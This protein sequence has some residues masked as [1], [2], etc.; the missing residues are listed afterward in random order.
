MLRFLIK[1]PIAVL[2]SFLGFLILGIVVFNILPI[3]L[4]PNVAIPQINVQL[5]YP[6]TAVREI[7]NTITQPLRNQLLQ[8]GQIKNIESLSRSGSATIRLQFDYS[9]NI[10]LAFIEVNEKIDQ[11]INYLPKDLERPR[12]IKANVSDIP[13]FY[14]SI[15]PKENN[16]SSLLELSEFT[17]SVLKRRIEQLPEVA[18]VD[19]SGFAKPQLI[20]QPDPIVFQSL[21][22][23]E[24][25]ISNALK[26]NNINLGNIL[27]KD[28][29]YQYNIRFLSEL[30]TK[31]DVENIFL[32]ISNRTLQLKDVAK[33]QLIE[34]PRRSLFLHNG[35]EGIIFS[36]RKQADAQLFAL[37]ASFEELLTAFK[38]DYPQ[39][40]FYV[41]N[42]QSELLEVSIDNLRTSLLYG[43]CFA[44]LVM[45]LFF[46]E[47]QMPLLI[48]IA[49]PVTLIISGFIFYLLG[50][51]INIISLSGL[52][53]GV[54]LMIDNSIIVIEN[55]RQ[56]QST[57]P[58]ITDACAEGANEV[59][60][61]LISS[62]LT[63][64]S[65]FLPLIFLSG[66]AGALFYDQAMSIMITLGTSLIVAY[67]LLPTLIR[68]SSN[69]RIIE[70]DIFRKNLFTR[71][72]DF[73]LRFKWVFI[74]LFLAFPT[75]TFFSLLSVG[76]AGSQIA[77]ESFPKLTRNALAINIDWNDAITVEESAKRINEFT[78]QYASN[79]SVST[80][81]IGE[82]QFLIQEEEK[83]INELS[84]LLFA[85]EESQLIPLKEELRD[86]FSNK[87]P[88]VIVNVE[89]QKNIFDQVFANTQAPLILDI[90]SSQS[91][92]TPSL[93]SI[94]D[95]SIWLKQQGI[96]YTFPATEE[97][98]FIQIL[99]EKAL[100][101][102]V[103]YQT[104]N[105]K[106]QSLFS[107]NFIGT[108]KSSEQYIPIN[109]GSKPKSLFRQLN[110][111]LITNNQKQY[112]PL[113]EFIQIE[114]STDYKTITA[115]KGGEALRL[116]LD[117]FSESLIKKIKEK[118]QTK[119][120]LS[121]DFSGQGFTDQELIKEL[122][123]ILAIALI[124]LYL[125]LAAQFESLIQPFIVMLTVPIGLSG[126]FWLL[127]FT[128][129]S[130]NLISLI[131]MIVMS[132]IVVN[133]A[134]LKVDMMNKL[135]LNH[136]KIEAIHGAGNRRLRPIIMTSLTTILA[137][138]PILFSK[139]LG[140]ELQ[141]PLAFAVIG[142]LLLGTVASLFFIP[143]VYALLKKV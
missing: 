132:G 20:I 79:S 59:I 98:Y 53:L 64:C 4:L 31:T 16:V 1:R 10:N 142:G 104:I 61:P 120:S 136:S 115:G 97:Q 86:H 66:I 68:L 51:S 138:L 71:S 65:V 67:I 135:S 102:D 93:E 137:L 12:V 143:L 85:K 3:S 89:E 118:V 54:G 28:G 121:V 18:F 39:L 34:K 111:T 84:L 70:K 124:L 41:T 47:W 114:K 122:I 7:E 62:A 15:V 42:D 141:T 119:A 140:A 128:N 130:L 131:G 133:D 101:Y 109:I 8:V 50:I 45:F 113:K 27:V 116:E 100:L 36:I 57:Y 23:T 127:V 38:S 6:N 2:M 55:I 117:Q 94:N 9:T 58:D 82:Q 81:L 29:L 5:N 26:A 17:R 91:S 87:Y 88:A 123:V 134:I 25:D 129:Q 19:R 110:Q 44:F 33:V 63:T 139:G 13:V 43:A 30:K 125:I 14:L 24:A 56:Q 108:L 48:G 92:N 105:N 112:I 32:S 96:N 74:L 11:V 76:Q 49:I 126:A 78:Q 60:R 35:R 73:M 106:L 52:I 83:S 46:W 103:S 107:Q 22:L 80:C 40:D 90:Q 37:K 95:L 72:V 75:F 69:K 99:R 77:Q 21:K